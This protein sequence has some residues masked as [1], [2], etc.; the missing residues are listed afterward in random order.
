MSGCKYIYTNRQLPPAK[1]FN[2]QQPWST[3]SLHIAT[4]TSLSVA[5]DP[6]ILWL[7]YKSTQDWSSANCLHAILGQCVWMLITK[8]VKLHGL[9]AQDP[10]DLMYLPASIIFGY[11][12]GF[13]KL[14]ACVTLRM[15]SP[16]CCKSI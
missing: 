12:H 15:V 9:F 16:L 1:Y 14:Y 2:S 3:Y 6:L 4:F 8:Y 13:I 11:F 10:M 5:F 7:A